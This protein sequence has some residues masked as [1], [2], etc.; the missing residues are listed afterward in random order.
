MFYDEWSPA[1]ML[2]NFIQ[3]ILRIY[4]RIL[5]IQWILKYPDNEWNARHYSKN[6]LDSILKQTNYLP[7][8]TVI[9]VKLNYS[10]DILYDIL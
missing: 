5:R 4:T 2:P 9:L 7:H 3:E 8:P 10:N 6:Q 1:Y